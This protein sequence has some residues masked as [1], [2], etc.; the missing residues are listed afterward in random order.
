[1]KKD[2]FF[3]DLGIKVVALILSLLIWFH[4]TTEKNYTEIIELPVS[5]TYNIP[6]SLVLLTTP[7]ERVRLRVTARGKSLLKLKYT[8]NFYHVDAG[9]LDVGKNIL[10]MT[11]GNIPGVEDIEV[12]EVSPQKVLFLVDRYSTKVIY[13]IKPVFVYDTARTHVY[14]RRIYPSTVRVRGPRTILRTLRYVL[15]DSIYLDTL[16]TGTYTRRVYLR[17]PVR[18]VHILKPNMVKVNFYL[19]HFLFDTVKTISSDSM[20]YVV[21]LKYPDTLR[22]IPDSVTCVADSVEKTVNCSV[23]DGV[24]LLKAIKK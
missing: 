24:V 4:A 6:D 20:S 22:F 9:K 10:D 14:P 19:V 17:S 8:K 21:F 18:L 1:M 16:K 7:P 23:P 13:S 5:Y 3:N 12:L 11:Q 2:D 15:T